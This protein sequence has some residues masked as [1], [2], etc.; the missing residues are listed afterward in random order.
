MEELEAYALT[1]PDLETQV[2]PTARGA[3]SNLCWDGISESATQYWQL[4]Q[5]EA[6]GR[7]RD[8]ASRN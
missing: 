4:H 1:H 5:T 8:L 3:L 7:D 2:M 6:A